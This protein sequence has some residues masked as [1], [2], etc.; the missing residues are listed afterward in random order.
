MLFFLTNILLTFFLKGLVGE[1]VTGGQVWF[2]ERREHSIVEKEN[3][4]KPWS[5]SDISNRSSGQYKLTFLIEILVSTS[6]L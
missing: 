4:L 2:V 6:Q 1:Q 5:V 3:M